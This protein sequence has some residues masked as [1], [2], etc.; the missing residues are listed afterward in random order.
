MKFYFYFLQDIFSNRLIISVIADRFSQQTHKLKTTKEIKQLPENTDYATRLPWASA[1][2][3]QDEVVRLFG[4]MEFLYLS[5]GD[6]AD[7]T[8]SCIFRNLIVSKTL[9]P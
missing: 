4:T 8:L 2:L 6:R 3:T 5:Q 1:S 9:S 7:I